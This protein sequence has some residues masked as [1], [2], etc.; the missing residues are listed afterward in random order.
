MVTQETG[1][2]VAA[3]PVAS[4]G[5]GGLQP[6]HQRFEPPHRTSRPLKN[7][8]L[9][10]VHQALSERNFKGKI[11]WDKHFSCANACVCVAHACNVRRS[12]IHACD[13][14]TVSPGASIIRNM[15]H[16]TCSVSL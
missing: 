8:K 1:T 4:G 6:H 9:V 3:R 2:R 16:V 13:T 11:R 15:I 5:A 12:V 7:F 10:P 14:A